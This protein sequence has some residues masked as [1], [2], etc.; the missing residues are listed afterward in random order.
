MYRA[1]SIEVSVTKGL[2]VIQEIHTRPKSQALF[3]SIR[4]K[5]LSGQH[6][7][8]QWLKQADLESEYGATRSEVRGALSSLAE[9]G[10]VEY[11]KNRGF[12]VFS[13]TE[14]EINEIAEMILALELAVAE[15]IIQNA[16][17]EDVEALRQNAADFEEVMR[18]GRQADL[19]VANYGFHGVVIDLCG[20]KLIARTVKHLREC[21]ASGPEVNYLTMDGLNKSNAEHYEIIAA[22]EAKDS[23]ELTACF[24]KHSSFRT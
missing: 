16:T 1:K 7:A 14:E 6:P 12:R 17:S 21:C 24:N 15:Q 8:G 23:A 13:R 10:V 11:V 3:E 2:L 22:I 20:N 19:R 5:I 4:A 18:S 9:R